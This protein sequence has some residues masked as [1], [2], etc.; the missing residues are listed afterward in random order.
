[1]AMPGE[2][3]CTGAKVPS[4]AIL[5]VTSSAA[6]YYIGYVDAGDGIP[7]T[8]ESEAY[9]ATG[10]EA[11]LAFTTGWVDRNGDFHVSHPDYTG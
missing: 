8:R 4:D 6:G 2:C 11:R 10:D 9:W 3:V 5:C 7:W 1:M